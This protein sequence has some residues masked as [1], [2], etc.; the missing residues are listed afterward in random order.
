MIDCKAK[1]LP[2][3]WKQYDS[4]HH[5]LACYYIDGNVKPLGSSKRCRKGKVTMLGRVMNCLEQVIIPD[6]YGHP[7]YFRTFSGNADLPKYALQSMAKLNELLN[8]TKKPNQS[9]C[10]RALIF[11]GGGN[12]VQNLRAFSKSP[13]HY[14]TIWD[15]NQIDERKFKPQSDMECYHYGKAML[16]DCCIEL[17]DSKE[18]KYIY[19][20][21]AILVH[22]TNGR[23]GCLVTSIPPEIFDAHE[24][25]KAYFDRWPQCE[26]QYAMMKAAVCFYQVVGYGNSPVDDLNRLERINEYQTYIQQL[27]PKLEVPISQITPISQ[28]LDKRFETE[29][30]LKESSQIKNG[31]RV[32]SEHD[33]DALKTCL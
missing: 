25:V 16:T 6:G 17:L 27:K 9:R 26:K 4:T 31:K 28:N 11:D 5:K 19:E 3:F 10:T 24:V 20:S 2:H 32:Q 33:F 15:T 22:W 12:S 18:P 14:I 13:Y 21:R 29:R 23:K 1:F 8:K 7:I 30:E